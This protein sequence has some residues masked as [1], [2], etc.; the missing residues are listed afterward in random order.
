M[1]DLQDALDQ[2]DKLK[3][4]ED[5]TSPAQVIMEAARRVANAP[6]VIPGVILAE[7]AAQDDQ[8]E[9]TALE[10]IDQLTEVVLEALGITGDE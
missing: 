5:M 10:S 1:S 4:D 9:M 6:E 2:W 7:I 8:P 3:F